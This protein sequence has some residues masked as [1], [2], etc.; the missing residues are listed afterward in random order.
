ME[1]GFSANLER[2]TILAQD[3]IA[4]QRFTPDWAYTQIYKTDVALG[5][6][7]NFIYGAENFGRFPDYAFGGSVSCV[8]GSHNVKV[9]IQD[10]WGTCRRTD[11]ANGDIR[12]IFNNGTAI[13]AQ[14]LNSPVERFDQLHADVGVFAQDSWTLKRLTVNYGARYETLRTRHPEGNLAGGPLHRRLRTFGPIDMPTWNSISP[15]GG[16]VY[17]IFG[18]QRT[19]LK[20]SI[21]KPQAGSTGFSESYKPVAADGR[22]RGV[23]GRESGRCSAG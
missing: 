11:D 10:T 13:Q 20:F 17:D 15:R 6:Q 14:I 9:G 18:N 5:T 16:L 3:G 2:Y 7:W 22:D 4:K 19:A 23:D 21:G 8:T 12:A 1:G